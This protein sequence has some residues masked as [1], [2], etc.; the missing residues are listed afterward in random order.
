MYL[1]DKSVVEVFNKAGFYIRKRKKIQEGM[2]QYVPSI[3]IQGYTEL[4]LKTLSN[5]LVE[6]G[7]KTDIKTKHNN[8]LYRVEI[9]GLDNINHLLK[10]YQID[11]PSEHFIMFKNFINHRLNQLLSNKKSRYDY[12]DEILYIAFK[13]AQVKKDL[14]ITVLQSITNIQNHLTVEI[15]DEN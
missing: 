13:T 5:T 7:V 15:K 2:F 9:S 8:R 11:I 14:N 4:S 12:R 6:K 1:E 3:C 10:S